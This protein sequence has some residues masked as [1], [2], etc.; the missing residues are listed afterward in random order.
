MPSSGILRREA[1]VRTGVSEELSADN[2][3][4]TSIAEL[5]TEP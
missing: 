4:V 1:H 5:G 2:I 3:E